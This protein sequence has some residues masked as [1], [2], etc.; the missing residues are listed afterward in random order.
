EPVASGRWTARKKARI[1]D[2]RRVG[3]ANIVR[4]L[5][6]TDGRPRVLVCS[7]AVGYYGNRGDEIL[8]ETSAPAD[9]FLAEVCRLWES[10]AAEAKRYGV[11]VVSARTGVVLSADGGALA[12]MLLPFRLGIAGRLGSGRQWM[13]WIHIDDMV[14]LLLHAATNDDIDGPMNATA[15]R[16]VT[17]REF[18]KT[19]AATLHRPAIL[20]MPGFALKLAVGQFAEVLLASQRVVPQVA[21]RTGYAFQ[22]PELMPALENLLCC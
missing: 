12:K 11:R 22:Y 19:L 9:D 6:A 8:D 1:R 20:P 18:T 21:Q 3:T 14:A 15:P 7:S 4:G 17:N 5:A 16:P 13:P 10:A 2:S